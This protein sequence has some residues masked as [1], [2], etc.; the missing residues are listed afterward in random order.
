MLTGFIDRVRLRDESHSVKLRHQPVVGC[1]RVLL[2]KAATTRAN[3]KQGIYCT[4]ED[5]GSS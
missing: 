5:V 4:Y 2:E 3:N 1:L